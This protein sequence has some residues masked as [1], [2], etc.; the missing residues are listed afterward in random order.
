MAQQCGRRS[1]QARD[2]AGHVRLVGKSAINGEAA[3]RNVAAH[4]RIDRPPGA[5]HEAVGSRTHAENA[6]KAAAE[7]AGVQ[8]GGFR[9][10][11]QRKRRVCAQ[12]FGQRIR[13]IVRSC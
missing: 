1:R 6:R 9:P 10:M 5:L 2:S 7:A 8:A 13:P 4:Q 3:Q 12:S 11:L